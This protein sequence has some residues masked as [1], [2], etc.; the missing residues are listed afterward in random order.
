MVVSDVFLNP[1]FLTP[2]L[3]QLFSDCFYHMHQRQKKKRPA[4][5]KATQPSFLVGYTVYGRSVPYKFTNSWSVRQKIYIWST[6][7]SIA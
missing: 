5:K 6:C 3:T 2:E 1:G 7:W 4:G